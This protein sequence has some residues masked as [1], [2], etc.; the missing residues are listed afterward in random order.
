MAFKFR[1]GIHPDGNKETTRQK[2]IEDLPA[3]QEI[4]IPMIMHIGAPCTPCVKVGHHVLLGEK[5]AV[6]ADNISIPI[7][8]SVSGHVKSIEPRPHPNGGQVLSV[9][10]ENDGEDTPHPTM[11]PY[12]SVESLSTEELV[13]IIQETGIV[14]LGGAAFPTHAK[15]R[16]GLGKVNTLIINGAEC[17]PYI[18]S[19]HRLMLEAP[20][21]IVGGLRVLLKIF[22]L[23]NAIIAIESNK[24]DA[25]E[26]LRHTLPKH[27]SGVRVHPL[28]TRYPQG[29]EKQLIYAV[30]GRE[31]PPGALPAAVGAAVFNV[32]TA[33]AIHR[34]V[35]TGR[36]LLRRIV[37]VSGSGVSN[38]KNLRVRL[39]TPLKTVFEATGGFKEQPFK[40][41]MG[42]P[43]MG[44]AQHSLDVPVI[45]ATNALLAFSRDEGAVEKNPVCIR[46]GRCV[47]SC[48]MRLLPVYLY[49]YEQKNMLSQCE[50]LH[51]SDCIE[52]GCCSYVCPGRLH[53]VHSMRNAKQKLREAL[54]KG[55]V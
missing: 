31:I 37:T 44:V 36:P 48:P 46:C 18:T 5:I 10:I 7:H 35:T 28:A 8:A 53:L 13:A 41:I 15:I 14:G 30:T 16:S 38:P 3:P 49:H 24:P 1:G 54:A 33:A 17:E 29:A 11:R 32:D 50:R 45:K 12:G 43:M 27:D 40:I 47:T 20:E 2:S 42:G 22:S 4:I 19:D 52:C 39:G 9:V 21:E 25:I 34:A 26:A 51:V 6:A 55:G 23:S